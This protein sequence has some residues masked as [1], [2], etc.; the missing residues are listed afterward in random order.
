M[1]T[2]TQS[3]FPLISYNVFYFDSNPK[4]N[5]ILPEKIKLYNRFVQWYYFNII[6]VSC[7]HYNS[8]HKSRTHRSLDFIRKYEQHS[9]Q[10]TQSILN[11]SGVREI[12]L[13]HQIRNIIYKQT[14]YKTRDI[15]NFIH[16]KTCKAVLLSLCLEFICKTCKHTWR[17]QNSK[18]TPPIICLTL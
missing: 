11:Y 6:K 3:F 14:I 7:I 13:K 8:N 2:N 10:T 17:I 18:S 4:Y 15:K 12:R 16:F 5:D 9:T 1:E